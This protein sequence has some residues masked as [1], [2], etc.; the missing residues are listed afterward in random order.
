ME[1]DIKILEDYIG[2]FKRNKSGVGLAQR[3]CNELAQA[4]EN[5]INRNKEQQ[6]EIEKLKI[7]KQEAWN[8]WNDLEQGSYEEENKLKSEL[9]KKDKIIDKMAVTINQAYFE[10]E[11]FWNWF[12]KILGI[13]QKMD[14]GYVEEKI[15]Q[16]FEKKVEDKQC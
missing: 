8:E 12:E 13:Q 3:H 6:E 16:Y 1:E 9:E 10:E 15:K 14:Y 11:K 7:E 5:L 2:I 4:I